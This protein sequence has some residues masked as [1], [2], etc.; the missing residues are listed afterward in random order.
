M[1][2]AVTK[3]TRFYRIVRTQWKL[4][5]TLIQVDFMPRALAALWKMSKSPFTGTGASALES[6]VDIIAVLLN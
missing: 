2:S 6:I 4:R 3:S 1:N 5:M